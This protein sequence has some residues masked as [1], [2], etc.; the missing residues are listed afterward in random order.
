[1]EN[2]H[3]EVIISTEHGTFIYSKTTYILAW[4]ITFIFGFLTAYII[5]S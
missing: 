2:K 3:K 5:F 1:M 4:V